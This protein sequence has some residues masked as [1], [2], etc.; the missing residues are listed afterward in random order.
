MAD[1]RSG[2][3]GWGAVPAAVFGAVAVLTLAGV[4]RRLAEYR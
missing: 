1:A 4:R 3:S 2:S